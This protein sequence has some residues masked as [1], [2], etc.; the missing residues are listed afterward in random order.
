MPEHD[1]TARTI[2]RKGMQEIRRENPAYADPFYRP[3]SKPNE[4]PTQINHGKDQIQTL[5]RWKRTITW[6]LRK[7]PHIKRVCYQEYTKGQT[8]H[9][10]KESLELQNLVNTGKSVQK[11]LP[12][13]TDIDKILK[14][15]QS[16][17]E[18]TF[19]CNCK[20][21]TGRIFNQPIF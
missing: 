20:R 10:S 14:I 13:Q 18:N 4:M 8:G 15:I 5:T 16:S 7:I 11:F 9:I 1:S 17:K 2:T 3:P 21:N 12:K 6:I 19:T